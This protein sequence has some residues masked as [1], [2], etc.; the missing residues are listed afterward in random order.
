MVHRSVVLGVSLYGAETQAPTQELVS[1]LNWFHQRCVHRI[2]GIK[3]TPVKFSGSK[4]S[5]L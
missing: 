3:R 2:L 4:N 1:K 5:L